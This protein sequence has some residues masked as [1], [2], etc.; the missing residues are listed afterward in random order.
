MKYEAY[1]YIYICCILYCTYYYYILYI[2]LVL[3]LYQ[4]LLEPYILHLLMSL[5]MLIAYE[6]GTMTTGCILYCIL[7]G[8]FFLF[9]CE[10]NEA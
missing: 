6:K 1:G 10:T 3:P 5:F 2:Y 7:Y 9:S 4:V 8:S